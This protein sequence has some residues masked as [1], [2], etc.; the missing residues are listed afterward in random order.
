MQF[1]DLFFL[2]CFVPVTL[3]LSF[4]ERS[5]EYKNFILFISSVLFFTWGRPFIVS[6]F[7][8]TA[9]FDWGMGLLCAPEKS[10]AVRV[11]AL[12]AD[13]VMNVFVFMLGAR[14][15]LFEGIELLTLSDKLIP[16]GAMFYGIRG[17]SYVYDVFSGRTPVEKNP[18]CILTYMVSFPLMP[19]GPVV[20]YGQ[21]RDQIRKREITG[22]KINAGL[23]RITLGLTKLSVLAPVL[24]KLCEAG[25]SENE[26]T[27]TGSWAGM[28]CYIF[29]FCVVFA[30][31][32]DMAIG[33]GKLFGFDYPESFKAIDMKKGIKGF[34][35]SFN[36]SLNHLMGDV[37][38]KP[39][40]AR[41]QLLGFLGILFSSAV[42]G[43][44]FS[45]SL[46]FIVAGL[47]TGLF[48]ILE[49]LFLKDTLEK[50]LPLLTWLYTGIILFV[51]FALT[52]FDSLSSLTQW[53]G[54]LI[55]RGEDYILSVALKNAV[56]Q[57]AFI[58]AVSVLCYLPFSR[59][60]F[61]KKLTAVSEKSA[62][63]YGVVRIMQTIALSVMLM[64]SVIALADAVI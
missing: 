46:F 40:R 7:L 28:L 51:V 53:A 47:V 17:F 10:K 61:A 25:L 63:L 34:A 33:L 20:R 35:N 55:G 62:R 4:L 36:S 27:V 64:L 49:E 39:L 16:V 23:T 19:A 15:S 44:W 1:T 38:V 13:L 14:N 41:G 48:I 32:T 3:L 21:I 57:N 59:S 54:G 31:Y 52:R 37:I 12:T 58:L 43:A 45:D 29:R 42:I 8:L 26:I 60:F 50:I 2:F 9:V 18:F 5:C 56:T 11:T 6:L 22:E 30:G 24:Q